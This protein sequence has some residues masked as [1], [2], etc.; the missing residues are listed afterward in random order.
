MTTTING[1]KYES[2]YIFSFLVN[3]KIRATIFNLPSR[4]YNTNTTIIEER[5][6]NIPFKSGNFYNCTAKLDDYAVINWFVTMQIKKVYVNWERSNTS[7]ERTTLNKLTGEIIKDRLV[8]GGIQD[9][10]T[11]PGRII[12]KPLTKIVI[13]EWYFSGK[14]NSLNDCP[15]RITYTPL[16]VT[17]EWHK[18]GN[19]E[20]I[21]G[22]PTKIITTQTQIREEW[23]FMGN[24]WKTNIIS[25]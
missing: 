7:V 9:E 1:K 18:N 10:N 24:V 6:T 14:L 8:N 20:R 17:K 3:D 2:G 21:S 12:Y 16:S 15:S 13:E 19:I 5:F 11:L 4:L 22:L 25:I 23:Y